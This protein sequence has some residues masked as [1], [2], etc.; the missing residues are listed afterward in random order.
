M[1]AVALP[2]CIRPGKWSTWSPGWFPIPEDDAEFGPALASSISAYG[3]RP[4]AEGGYPHIL[5]RGAR[6]WQTCG[7]CQL[8][9]HPDRDERKRRYQMLT[10]SGV[11]VQHPDG[12]LEAMPPQKAASYLSAMDLQARALYEKI[13]SK[14]KR[15]LKNPDPSLLR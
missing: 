11:V 12:T 1:S 4:E 2:V 8:V 15:R 3:N 7:N 9:C 13:E 6:L 10:R 14:A 5:L